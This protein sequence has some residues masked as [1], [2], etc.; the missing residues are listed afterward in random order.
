MATRHLKACEI[1]ASRFALS[2]LRIKADKKLCLFQ[3]YQYVHICLNTGRIRTHLAAPRHPHPFLGLKAVLP[4][5]TAA[6][7]PG[8]LNDSHAVQARLASAHAY[9]L[10]RS[11]RLAN[12]L[13]LTCAQ[14]SMVWC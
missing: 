6:R 9:I 10:A 1:I 11:P 4:C 14:V 13:D 7:R 8:W 3:S 5:A 2:A 12:A